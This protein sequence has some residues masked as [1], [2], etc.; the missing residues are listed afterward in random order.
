MNGNWVGKRIEWERNVVSTKTG[1]KKRKVRLFDFHITHTT[2][3]GRV[4]ITAG[5][6]REGGLGGEWIAFQTFLQEKSFFWK[7]SGRRS[8]KGGGEEGSSAR[9]SVKWRK[10][11]GV[12]K[13]ALDRLGALPET[14]RSGNQRGWKREGKLKENR[15]GARKVVASRGVTSNP[16]PEVR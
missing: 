2:A 10:W 13:G 4:G 14:G 6:G 5:R 1:Q 12:K 8:Q 15:E 7:R 9:S 11:W 3:S 16:F